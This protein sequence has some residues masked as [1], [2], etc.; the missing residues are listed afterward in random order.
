MLKKVFWKLFWS[1]NI[2]TLCLNAQRWSFNNTNQIYIIDP[3]TEI[4]EIK[5]KFS[6]LGGGELT[7]GVGFTI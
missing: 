4:L 3:N 5:L 6:P 2:R 7:A 1:I